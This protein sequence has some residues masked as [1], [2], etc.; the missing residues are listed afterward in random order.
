MA[1]REDEIHRLRTEIFDREAE[2]TLLKTR[3]RR[4]ESQDVPADDKTTVPSGRTVTPPDYVA[5]GPGLITS[6]QD[7]TSS[8]WRWPLSRAEYQRYGRQMI[9]PEIGLEGE[10]TVAVIALF[11]LTTGDRSIAAETIINVNRGRWWLRLSSRSI[12]C[13]SG[14][15]DIRVS[16]RRHGRNIQST[17]TNIA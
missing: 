15:R 1:R 17:S 6:G 10:P 12:P 8:S 5:L 16:R 13:G 2:L 11:G 7:A 9:T 3:L 4:V 14:C